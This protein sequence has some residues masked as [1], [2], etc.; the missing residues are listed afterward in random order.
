[1][2]LRGNLRDGSIFTSNSDD[3]ARGL[4]GIGEVVFRER[5]VNQ[6]AVD[7]LLKD[8]C[9]RWDWS[10]ALHTDIYML[11][12]ILKEAQIVSLDWMVFLARAGRVGVATS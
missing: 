6:S 3:I 11:A 4:A 12:D 5:S 9:P 7:S 1:M 2:G 8:Y 10:L